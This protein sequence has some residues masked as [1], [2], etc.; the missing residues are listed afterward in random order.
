MALYSARATCFQNSG[1]ILRDASLAILDRR[2]QW[3]ASSLRE[4][5]PQSTPLLNRHTRDHIPDSHE[6]MPLNMQH[7]PK[8]DRAAHKQLGSCL[9]QGQ[10]MKH[11]PPN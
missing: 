5:V 10:A 3:S 4:S 8:V 11:P 7:I 2:S 1:V 6:F 9:R